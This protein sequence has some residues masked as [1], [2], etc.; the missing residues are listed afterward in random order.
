MTRSSRM[1]RAVVLLSAAMAGAAAVSLAQVAQPFGGMRW[2]MVGPFRGGRTLTATGVPG[3]PDHFY[4][5][6]VGGGVWESRN[7]GRTWAPIFDTQPIASVGAIAVAPSNPRVLYAGTGE[8]DMRSDISYGN[9]VYRSSDAGKTWTHAGLSETRQIGR[10]LVD[11]RDPELVFVAALGHAYGPN[12][13]RGVFRSKDG[14]RSWSRVL[15]VDEN[16]GA[17]DLAFD[18]GDSKKILA[19]AWRTRRPPW[20]VYAP[21]NGPGSGI[22]RSDDGGDTWRRA[23]EGLP[24]EGA[25]RIGLA[26]SASDRTRAY[27]LVDAKPGGGLYASRDGGSRWQLVSNDRRI[28]ERGWYFG[29]VTVDTKNPEVVYVCNTAMYR[30]TDGGRTFVPVKGA[31]GGDDYHH[32]W[33]DP[34]DPRR[35]I[36]ASDQ[37]AVVSVDGAA[38][39]SSWYN[40]PTAQ[41][42]HVTADDRSPY[43]IYGAQQ[44]S[45]AVANPSRTDYR[46]ITL[47]DWRPIAGGGESGSIAPDPKNASIL[48]GE[49]VGR[50]D[51]T[52]LQEQSID[53]TLAYPGEY[54]RTWTLPLIFSPRDPKSLYFSNQFVF[55]T[56]DEGRHWAKISP[57]L[58]RENPGVPPNLDAI[59]AANAAVKAPRRG[60]VYTLAPSSLRDGLL[61]AGTDDGLVWITRDEGGHWDNV[62]PRELSAWSKVGILEASHFD[63]ETAYAA[64]DRHR[65]EDLRPYIYRTRDGGKTWKAAAEG[66]PEGSY[67]NA[68]REDPARRGLLY[69]GTETGVFVSFDDGER[70]QPLQ[71][72]L[73]HCSVRDLV[74]THGDLA[75]ATHGRSFWILDDLAPVRQWTPASAAEKTWLF[76]PRDAVRIHPAPFQGTPDPLDEPSGENPPAGA[77]LDY[78][79]PAGVS[80]PVTLEIVN[81]AGEPVRRF[82][83][84][85]PPKTADLGKIQVAP[86]WVPPAL[87]PSAVPGMHRF[88]WDLR[89][90]LPEA[91]HDPQ[92]RRE[93]S[94]PLAAPGLYTVR[95]TAGG[96]R[97]EQPL[98]IVR[99]P[100][101]AASDADLASQLDLALKIQAERVRLAQ[102]IRRGDALTKSAAALRSRAKAGGDELDRLAKRVE[103]VVGKRP[104]PGEED[105]EEGEGAPSLRTAA[106]S[107]QR[108]SQTIQTAD[109]AP[110]PDALK[111]FENRRE[112]AARSMAQWEE[113]LR[114]DLPRV[115]RALA[116]A[117]LEPLRAE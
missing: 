89:H 73:P 62:T 29:G 5:G 74:V 36:V 79:L 4:F 33:V 95:L 2:R 100:R 53:P 1:R 23:G 103:R 21:S 115:N 72:N 106:S 66:I 102:A 48:Y 110:T 28:W 44:D 45:G 38:T 7:A 111:G 59:A 47:R 105:S 97:R 16:T 54:R 63:P 37:G 30:S 108:L 6:A 35:M 77:L 75:I 14:G 22:F 26:F 92:S 109:A 11:P 46:G 90:A 31:P 112:T 61:W 50:F 82:S 24:R 51:L 34:A 18:P 107:L 17:I 9:G 39:W 19:A 13:E 42:Y 20:N 99:D 116:G 98:R 101:L 15:F 64:V 84:V 113:L 88:V 86:E 55:K 76:A 25:G 40:Q 94:G 27:A 81:A 114:T 41:L 78:T 52:T 49:A 58:T 60:V 85:D 57:D 83:S 69:A 87:A 117:G 32:L 71:L 70:W 10:I 12:P 43:W 68:V 104:V 56:A 91:L 96:L 93:E 80:A 67:V 8:A 3:E 65:L